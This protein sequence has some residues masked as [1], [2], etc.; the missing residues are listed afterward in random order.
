MATTLNL[1]DHLLRPLVNATPG[2]SDATDFLG[3]AVQ[4][5]DIDYIDRDLV[6]TTW[7]IST[8]VALGDYTVLSTGETLK[9]IEAGTTAGA[10]EPTAPGYGGTVVD[11]TV[12]WQQVS[13]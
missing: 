4:V 9:A 8:A 10:T 12:T 3:R 7:A 2:T 1:R 6:G 11:G 13:G 5:G